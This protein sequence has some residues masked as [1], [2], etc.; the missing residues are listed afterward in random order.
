MGWVFSEKNNFK[1][2]VSLLL[3]AI[4]LLVPETLQQAFVNLLEKTLALITKG[5]YSKDS[6]WSKLASSL[7]I[8]S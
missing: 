6:I 7:A 1:G 5:S 4:Y 3:H 2:L 8:A